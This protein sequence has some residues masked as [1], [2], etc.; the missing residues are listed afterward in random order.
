MEI[1]LRYSGLIQ[2]SEANDATLKKV[3]VVPH[4]LGNKYVVHMMTRRKQWNVPTCENYTLKSSWNEPNDNDNMRHLN[5]LPVATLTILHQDDLMKR[6]N[7]ITATWRIGFLEKKDDNL[8]HTAPNQWNHHPTKMD[9]LPKTV[10]H[11][12]LATK[13]FV[14]HSSTVRHPTSSDDLCLIF[15]LIILLW[16]PP[17]KRWGISG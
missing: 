9:V 4:V 16:F 6:M 2:P 13:W 3:F 15:C 17:R 10:L 8:V 11:I 1:F 14:R 5:S 7:R 12:I